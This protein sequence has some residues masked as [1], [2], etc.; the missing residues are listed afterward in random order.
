[1]DLVLQEIAKVF[2]LLTSLDLEVLRITRL[3]LIVSLM[4]TITCCRVPRR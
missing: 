2:Q 3:S 4:A 1:M